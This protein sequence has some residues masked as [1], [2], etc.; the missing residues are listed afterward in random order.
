[1]VDF[2][3][4]ELE[5]SKI[6]PQMWKSQLKNRFRTE[7]QQAKKFSSVQPTAVGKGKLIF[8]NF[9]NF[10][11]ELCNSKTFGEKKIFSKNFQKTLFGN[12]DHEGGLK[13]FFNIY[14]KLFSVKNPR[15]K[16]VSDFRYLQKCGLQELNSIFRGFDANLGKMPGGGRGGGH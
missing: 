10:L 5:K 9:F 16:V 11:A 1:M 7:P 13:S 2:G 15:G 8:L 6:K 12:F 14:R 3:G 4:T